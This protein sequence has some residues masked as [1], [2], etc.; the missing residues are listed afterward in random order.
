M[1][2]IPALRGKG[3]HISEFKASLV[4]RVSFRAAR[5]TK[6]N[7]PCLKDRDR[8]RET[9][10]QRDRDRERER[11]RERET[12]RQRQRERERERKTKQNKS[13]QTKMFH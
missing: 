9:E 1:P 4:Y 5:I 2:L 7:Q 8:D 12:E 13:K 6:R 3:W 11:Q 10:R